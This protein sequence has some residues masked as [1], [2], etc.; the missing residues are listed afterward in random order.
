M[1]L[2]KNTFTKH[3]L[4]ILEIVIVIG[5]FLFL[6]NMSNVQYIVYAMFLRMIF[7]IVNMKIKQ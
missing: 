6:L 1:S 4:Y 5:T 3:S 2:V 7:N